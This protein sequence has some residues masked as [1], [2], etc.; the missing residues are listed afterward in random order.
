MIDVHTHCLLPEH[1]GTEWAEHWEPTTRQPWPRVEVADFDEAMAAGGVRTALV[2]GIRATARGVSTPPEFVADF[3]ARSRTHTIGFMALDLS[4]EDVLAQLATG[5]GLGLRGAKLYP[6]MAGFDPADA[7]H[8]EF[9][10]RAS[11]A[12]IVLIWHMGA[13]VTPVGRLSVSQPLALDEVARRH[14]DL[15]Q[16]IAHVGSPWQRDAIAVMRKNSNVYADVSGIWKRPFEGYTALVMAQEYDVVGKLLFGS[17]YPL[18][19]PAEVAAGL[20]A[21]SKIAPDGLPAVERATIDWLL[22]DDALAG[23]GLAG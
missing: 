22:S 14:P 11:A 19:T 12:G 3:C 4:D 18:H 16:I 15:V 20:A 2:F 23:L 21:L 7:G 5:I 1:W 9:Y 13:T 10:R 6:A 8:D 17:D